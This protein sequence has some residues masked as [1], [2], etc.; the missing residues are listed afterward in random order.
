MARTARFTM[1]VTAMTLSACATPPPA[2]GPSFGPLFQPMLTQATTN[3]VPPSGGN[4]CVVTMKA[5]PSVGITFQVSAEPAVPPTS[6]DTVPFY[7][8]LDPRFAFFEED[9]VFV[10]TDSNPYQ[11]I[12]FVNSMRASMPAPSPSYGLALPG[13]AK[14]DA[15]YAI[16]FHRLNPE[17][18]RGQRWMCDPTIVHADTFVFARALSPVTVRCFMIR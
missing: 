6:A 1:L 18:K 13:G 7:W 4:L 5:D 10:S 15:V 11:Y 17:G 12:G 9:G 16:I 3:C 8:D 2:P 14:P